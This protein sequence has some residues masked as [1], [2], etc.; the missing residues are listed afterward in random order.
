MDTNFVESLRNFTNYFFSKYKDQGFDKIGDRSFSNGYLHRNYDNKKHYDFLC[1]ILN[2]QITHENF[3]ICSYDLFNEFAKDSSNFENFHLIKDNICIVRFL[4]YIIK[5]KHPN[6]SHKLD[7]TQINILKNIYFSFNDAFSNNTEHFEL[8][9]QE[10][11]TSYLAN[12]PTVGNVASNSNSYSN[13]LN[14]MLRVNQKYFQRLFNVVK[15]IVRFENHIRILD[16]HQSKENPT[17]P[18]SLFFQKFPEPFLPEVEDFV[19]EYNEEIRAF[20]GKIINLNRKYLN[21][22][23]DKAKEFV[24]SFKNDFEENVI[25]NGFKYD[26][27]YRIIRNEVDDFYKAH[28]L[29]KTMQAQRA[30]VVEFVAKRRFSNSNNDSNQ[31][32]SD[33]DTVNNTMMNS[34]RGNYSFLSNFDPN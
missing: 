6:E 4:S 7:D 5:F 15:K 27:V 33:R 26:D 13:N 22:G 21:L 16:I 23:I 32:H 29:K 10:T 20:Q 2:K 11:A 14:Q 9:A 1:G 18:P 8:I 24:N 34:S 28:F 12:L 3:L 31:R 19:K 25:F 30:R 17:T